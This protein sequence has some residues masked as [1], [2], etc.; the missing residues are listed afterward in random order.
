MQDGG[1]SRRATPRVERDQD[2]REDLVDMEMQARV[3]P[4]ARAMMEEAKT[5]GAP[6]PA[7]LGCL[8]CQGGTVMEAAGAMEAVM[9]GTEV[10]NSSQ[11]PTA[12]LMTMFMPQCLLRW[13]EAK[14]R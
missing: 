14:S 7:I 1:R 3:E 9:E 6:R 13:S 12:T 8:G 2:L 11:I 10:D 5:P 4:V